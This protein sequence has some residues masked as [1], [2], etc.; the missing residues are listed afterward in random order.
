V[1]AY[2]FLGAGRVAPFTG[3]RWP[4]DEW[5][6]AAE[7]GRCRHGV[8]ACR[9]DQLPYWLGRELWD[10][11]LDGRI[12]EHERKIVATRGRLMRRREEWTPALLYDFAGDVLR[13][14]RRRFGAVAGLGGYVADIEWFRANG[15]VGLVAFGAAR[16]AEI[17]GGPA[18]YHAERARQ[19]RWLAERL[20]LDG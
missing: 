12:V 14:S 4:V 7:V 6:E 2:K 18:A 19:A 20:G 13:R 5:V 1:I 10:V 9:A 15:H 8:H 3:F 16:A 17:A 11:E